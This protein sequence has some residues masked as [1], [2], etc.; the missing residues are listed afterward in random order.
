DRDREGV[1]TD[2]IVEH[3][4]HAKVEHAER[5]L[6]AAR[7]TFGHNGAHGHASAV[8]GFGSALEFPFEVLVRDWMRVDDAVAFGVGLLLRVGGALA[9]Q[10]TAVAL[11]ALDRELAVIGVLLE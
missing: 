1:H 10:F 7:G 5:G 11:A 8:V 2:P 4:A 3:L 6:F 9:V